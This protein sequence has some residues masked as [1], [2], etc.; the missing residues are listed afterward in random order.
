MK[1]PT[2]PI[3][4]NF[5]FPEHQIFEEQKYKNRMWIYKK[6]MEKYERIH[7]KEP[8]PEPLTEEEEEIKGWNLSFN[9]W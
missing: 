3:K 2:K 5:Y 1:K 6:K 8:E 4:Y 9:I 7:P